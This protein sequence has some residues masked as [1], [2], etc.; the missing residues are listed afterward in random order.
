MDEHGRLLHWL[1][2]RRDRTPYRKALAYRGPHDFVLQHGERH[3]VQR[4]PMMGAPRVCFGNAFAVSY[5]VGGRY[6]EGYAIPLPFAEPVHHAWVQLDG[7]Y[8]EL[9][10]PSPGLAYHGV[11]FRPERADDCTWN[12]DASVLDDFRRGWPLLQEPW[13][14]EDWEAQWPDNERLQIIRTGDRAAAHEWLE[15]EYSIQKAPTRGGS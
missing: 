3:L 8:F 15:R 9:T 1:G 13:Q 12:G 7:R 4:S 6:V 14:G 2:V 10:W 11:E 5:S